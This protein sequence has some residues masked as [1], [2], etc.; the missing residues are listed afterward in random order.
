MQE[1]AEAYI[2]YF[3]NNL[4]DEI[5]FMLFK[6]VME[7]KMKGKSNSTDERTCHL[8]SCFQ[9]IAYVIYLA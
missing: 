3:L 1:P 5:E 6:F 2:E 7:T 8:L 9:A 4:N